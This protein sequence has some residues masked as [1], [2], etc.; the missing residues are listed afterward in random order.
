MD[1]CVQMAAAT[2]RAFSRTGQ[3]SA[4]VVKALPVSSTLLPPVSGIRGMM[5]Q[6]ESSGAGGSGSRMEG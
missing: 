6:D 4:R 1:E 5:T 3:R 2:G